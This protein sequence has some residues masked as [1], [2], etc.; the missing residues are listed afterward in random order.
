MKIKD[1]TKKNIPEKYLNPVLEFKRGIQKRFT[2]KI[3][4]SQ[5]GEDLILDFLLTHILKIK[6]ITYL[7]LGAHH[8]SFLSNTFY[9][10]KRGSTGVLVEPDPSLYLEI[11]KRRPEDKVLNVGV[12]VTNTRE[13]DFYVF[14]YK[15]LNTFSKEIAE[16]TKEEAELK[17]IIKMPLI[18]VNKI[19]EENF[20]DCPSFISVDIE[21]LDLD[22]IRNLDFKKWRPAAVCVETIRRSNRE[23]IQ[24][25]TDIMVQNN[26]EVYGETYINTIYVNG[27]LNIS[28][29]R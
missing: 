7:D 28:A 27:D 18:T 29:L 20:I 9:F 19:L 2:R 15:E 23:K 1:F 10:Y 21:G 6:S 17:S 11:K 5:S 12:G 3:S 24:E 16:E 4:Y 25:I 14:N 13:A 26:Y 22:I 8:S